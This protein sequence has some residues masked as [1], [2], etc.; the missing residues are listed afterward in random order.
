MGNEGF[1]RWMVD[2]VLRLTYLAMTGNRR[3]ERESDAW[4]LRR[5]T[6]QRSLH[7]VPSSSKDKR[8]MLALH[9]RPSKVHVH[10]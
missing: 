1:K 7:V 8:F 5:R 4:T 9:Y 6:R 3:A 10:R 2:A